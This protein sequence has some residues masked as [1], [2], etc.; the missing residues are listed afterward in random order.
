[1]K[2]GEAID[3]TTLSGRQVYRIERIFLV[4]PEDV[5][6]LSPSSSWTLTF[7]SELVALSK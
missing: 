1:M 3:L 7:A 4:S 6:V 5:S 2:P